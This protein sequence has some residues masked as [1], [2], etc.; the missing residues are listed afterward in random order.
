MGTG[1]APYQEAAIKG[2]ARVSMMQRLGQI[3][4][5]AGQGITA[6]QNAQNPFEAG[7]L[8]FAGSFGASNAAKQAAEA[9]AMKKIEAERAQEERQ[10]R[11]G[12]IEAQTAR[13]SRPEKSPPPPKVP[14]KQQDYE[15]LT[16][17]PEKGGL[18]LSPT[19]ARQIV[20]GMT[21]SEQVNQKKSERP[22]AA[23][24]DTSWIPSYVTTTRSGQKFLDISQLTGKD[25]AAAV[26]YA[27]S[28]GIPALGTTEIGQLQDI[29]AAS[30][31]VEDVLDQLHGMLPADAQARLAA[32][33]GI[34]LSALLQTN[35]QVAA[36][37]TWRGSAIRTLRATAGSKGLRLNQ[38]EIDIA[39]KNEI[40]QITDT[41]DVAVK[42]MENVKKML[43]NASNPILSRRW[44]PGAAAGTA[45]PKAA[46]GDPLDAFYK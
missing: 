44:G 35:A 23:V 39:V 18:G 2:Q 20:Y 6:S 10:A 32:Y 40:P 25:H 30:S 45:P 21:A 9:Y 3:F 41:Y 15:H 11:L 22:P 5:G 19:E 17:P 29:E 38:K 16:D 14:G 4:A 7:A 37:N 33:P 43:H 13:A 12:L 42:K 1:Y 46:H 27:A 26:R 31:N 24:Q 8:G 34:R 28:Q 36:F